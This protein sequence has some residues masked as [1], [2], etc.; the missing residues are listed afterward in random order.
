MYTLEQKYLYISI[1]TI[2]F[3]KQLFNKWVLE[4]ANQEYEG[5]LRAFRIEIDKNG[6]C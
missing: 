4:V 5:N 1:H 3:M 2:V 6:V